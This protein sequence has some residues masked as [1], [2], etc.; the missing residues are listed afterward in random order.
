MIIEEYIYLP[1]DKEELKSIMRRYEEVGLPGAMGFMDVV[2][3]K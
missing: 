3:V 1:H 2:H